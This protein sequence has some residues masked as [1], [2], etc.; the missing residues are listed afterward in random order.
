MSVEFVKLVGS[1]AHSLSLSVRTE[2]AIIEVGIVKSNSH[3]AVVIG[4]STSILVSIGLKWE[5][6]K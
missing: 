1:S 4:D 3:G 2:A 6:D 5:F